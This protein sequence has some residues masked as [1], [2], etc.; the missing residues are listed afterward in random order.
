MSEIDYEKSYADC[1]AY[2]GSSPT[3]WLDDYLR[4]GEVGRVLDLGSGQGRNSLHLAR[5]GFDVTAVDSS[6]A[7]I[8]E[9]RRQA[10]R[11]G[12]EI[13]AV[14]EDIRDLSVDAGRYDAVVC[15]TVLCHL[16]AESIPA[17]M[18]R[19]CRGL[20]PGGLVL[21]EEFTDEDPGARG[22][23]AA[24]EFAPIVNNYF[25]P[26]QMRDMFAGLE[27]VMCEVVTVVD[28]THGHRHQHSLLRYVGRKVGGGEKDL[29]ASAEK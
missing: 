17:I 2:F 15:V 27:R 1:S 5:R 28:S 22:S 9:L 13:E 25:S 29:D 21:A 19:I 11:E 23:G 7:A 14:C 26:A 18:Q 20:R 12:L 4:P 8:Q 16:A 3:L 6:R 10:L 24:S